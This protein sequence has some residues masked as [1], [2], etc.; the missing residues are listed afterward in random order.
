MKRKNVFQLL[1]LAGLSSAAEPAAAQRPN[2]I[3]ILTDDMGCGDVSAYGGKQGDTPNIDR[4]ASEGT[5]F[6]QFHVASPICSPSRA[7]FTTG[8]FPARQRINSYLH[9]RSGNRECEQVDWLD[10]ATPTLARTLKQ[11]GY[12]TGHFGKWHM[13]GGRDVQNA[14]QPSAYGY[15]EYHL[16]CE[17]IGPRFEDSGNAKKPTLNSEDGKE[18]YR[19]DFTKYWVDRSVDF[20]QR[21]K[22]QPFYLE[23]WPQDVHTPH[24]PG[25][26]ALAR[27][28]T[29]GLPPPQQNFR[30]V[31]N[32]YDRQI[33]RF[34][35]ALREMGLDTNTIVIFTADNGPDPSFDHAR[36]LGMRGMKKSLYEG[37]T[38][39]P[40]IVR[41]TGKVPVGKVNDTSVL[42]SVDYFPTVCALAG[43]KP[44]E[45]AAFD[46]MD[47]SGV[48]LGGNESRTKL[49]FWEYGRNAKG[50]IYPHD[51]GD[52]SPNVA[53][54]DGRWKLLVNADG[55]G[56]ELFDLAA[57]PL[58][59][60]NVAE[61]Y[62]ERA[63]KLK[64]TAL[65]WRK[66]LPS[67]GAEQ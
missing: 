27:T 65:N 50:Y 19:Y 45:Q 43:V 54:R 26:E 15:D 16:N 25:R 40:F 30:A 17:G 55:S 20:I 37:G 4:L 51:P 29:P 12:V 39:E 53:V 47:M 41:W 46:G 11:A 2:V 61:L 59:T 1:A 64:E 67:V 34:M 13:G 42:S 22:D 21:H 58:E 44:P 14:P 56:T 31:L 63:G 52:K 9:S 49:L 3:F 23:L 36:T 60:K 5:R 18:Y 62:P 66:S 48:W 38:C 28:A 35:D 32:E 33:G 7:A 10:P 6:T 57:D 8:Q 24:T